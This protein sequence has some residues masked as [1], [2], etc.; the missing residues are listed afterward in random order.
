MPRQGKIVWAC[1]CWM[2]IGLDA[3]IRDPF[4]ACSYADDQAKFG[5]VGG[6]CSV[7]SSEYSATE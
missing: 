2:S 5:D 4:L 7:V 6:N 1:C 3:P